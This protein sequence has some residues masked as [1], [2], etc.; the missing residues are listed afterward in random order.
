M[1]SSIDRK[2]K[3]VFGCIYTFG[4]RDSVEQFDVLKLSSKSLGLLYGIYSTE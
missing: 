3:K 1:E 2:K 4:F